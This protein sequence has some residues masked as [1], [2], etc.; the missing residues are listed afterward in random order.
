M[1]KGKQLSPLFCE[2][3]NGHF[4]VRNNTRGSTYSSEKKTIIDNDDD[5]TVRHHLSNLNGTYEPYN[6]EYINHRH[7]VNCCINYVL[8]FA[9]FTIIMYWTEI[10]QGVHENSTYHTNRP[11][12]CAVV[13]SDIFKN[14]GLCWKLLLGQ[15]WF[16]FH[17][18]SYSSCC[19]HSMGTQI[20]YASPP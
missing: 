15:A 10:G 2:Y 8:V 1:N 17:C 14:E 20:R 3:V 7:R 4:S 18:T 13:P 11:F 16:E 5:G 19:T 9:L 12:D 6:E